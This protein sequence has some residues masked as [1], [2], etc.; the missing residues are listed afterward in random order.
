MF[1]Q[2]T[3]YYEIGEI[4]QAETLERVEN[5]VNV[6]NCE[7]HYR[8]KNPTTTK[9]TWV[10]LCVIPVHIS[11]KNDQLLKRNGSLK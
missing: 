6:N 2:K 9:K 1:L 10:I 5:D 3:Y 4:F 11:G 8:G 7:K